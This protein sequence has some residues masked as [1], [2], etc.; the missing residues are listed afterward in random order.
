MYIGKNA[1]IGFCH[2]SH[3][4]LSLLQYT[5]SEHSTA[6]ETE[7]VEERSR[8]LAAKMWNTPQTH[9]NV[10]SSTTFKFDR[11]L[12]MRRSKC[13]TKFDFVWIRNAKD[14]VKCILVTEAH[15]GFCRSSHWP[16]SLSHCTLS[17]HSAA[18]ET[19]TVKE[20]SR[21]L[22]AKMWNT[23]H[24]HKHVQ[25]STTLDCLW[26]WINKRQFPNLR[27]IQNPTHAKHNQTTSTDRAW[28]HL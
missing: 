27:T 19:E 25:S 6:P 9:K 18:P 17:E 14:I 7:T 12:A 2:S 24:T 3:W 16:L 21:A 20:R 1:H 26:L 10:Q 11:C 23:P 13:S 28:C 22:A 15:I 8:A 4:P 5:L